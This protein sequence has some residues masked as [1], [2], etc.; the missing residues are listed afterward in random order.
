VAQRRTTTLLFAFPA[1]VRAEWDNGIIR[2]RQ[3]IAH[4]IFG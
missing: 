4:Q 3:R 1:N 2:R